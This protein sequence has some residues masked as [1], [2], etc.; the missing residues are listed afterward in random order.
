[1]GINGLLPVLSPITN[2]VHISQFSGNKVAIDI[3]CWLHKGVYGCCMELCQ[4]IPTT[5]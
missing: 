3:Y 4:N 2:D 1:M 5:K